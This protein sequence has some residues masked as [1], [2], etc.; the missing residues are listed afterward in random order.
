R[1]EHEQQQPLARVVGDAVLTARGGDQRFARLQRVLGSVEREATAAFEHDVDLVLAI[2]RV[3]LLGLVG[4]EAI[5]IDLSPRRGGEP[6]LRHPVGLVLRAIGKAN[7]HRSSHCMALRIARASSVTGWTTS[8]S[9]PRS[10]AP[11]AICSRQPGLPVT[12]VRAPVCAIRDI[13]SASNRSAISGSSTLYTPAL[14]Q[15][16][17]LSGNG[18]S[19]SSGIRPSSARGAVR[20]RWP[21][22]R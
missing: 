1:H 4:L 19:R 2:V 5:E 17:S 15:Q 12:T 3:N 10:R 21:C 14:P 22:A 16:S 7:L 13:L 11:R 18:T 9:R 8:R 6:D 20:T